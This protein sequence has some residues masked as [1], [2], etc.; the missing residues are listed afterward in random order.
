LQTVQ[1]LGRRKREEMKSYVNVPRPRVMP[2]Y[3]VKKVENGL[4]FIKERRELFKEIKVN[5][6]EG[7]LALQI[8]KVE[9]FLDRIACLDAACSG[10]PFSWRDD[11]DAGMELIEEMRWFQKDLRSS[12]YSPN[13]HCCGGDCKCNNKCKDCKCNEG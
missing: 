1:A 5:P 8:Y 2:E 6:D 3:L 13:E 10:I 11:Y 12:K 4:A 7:R 9:K